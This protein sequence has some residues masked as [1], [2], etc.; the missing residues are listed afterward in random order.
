MQ[1][2]LV[3]LV[4]HSCTPIWLCWTDFCG[5]GILLTLVSELV[6]PLLGERSPCQPCGSGQLAAA[7]KHIRLLLSAAGANGR[8]QPR[9]VFCL[10]YHAVTVFKQLLSKEVEFGTAD[11]LRCWV[12]L[13]DCKL[14]QFFGCVFTQ[15]GG[16]QNL[17]QTCTLTEIRLLHSH[18]TWPK[19]S[20]DK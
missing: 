6:Q 20:R 19:V 7:K 15:L 1:S 3:V 16:W 13:A 10:A 18:Q 5:K 14:L 9:Y 12:C 2:N 17:K 4:S 11:M 8:L